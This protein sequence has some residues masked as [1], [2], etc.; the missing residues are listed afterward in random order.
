M[1]LTQMN[2]EGN[3]ERAEKN[4]E[5]IEEGEH[6]DVADKKETKKEVLTYRWTQEE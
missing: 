2:V 5:E 1:V 4:E 3:T 6:L